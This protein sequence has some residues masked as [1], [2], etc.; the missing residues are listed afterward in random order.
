MVA[1]HFITFD[2]E[3]F[4]GENSGSI[5]DSLFTP[6]EIILNILESAKLKA[7][8]FIDVLHYYKIIS[9]KGKYPALE[10]EARAFKRQIE[11]MVKLGHDIQLH[12]HPHWLDALYNPKTNRWEFSYEHYRLHD[13]TSHSRDEYSMAKCFSLAKNILVDLVREL[14]STYDCTCFRAGGYCILPFKDLRTIFEEN[15]I[16]VDSSIL[17]KSKFAIGQGIEV[18]FVKTPQFTYWFFSDDPTISQREG[19]FLELP[20]AT[21][22][23][24]TFIQLLLKARR[25][26]TRRKQAWQK[27]SVG[28]AMSQIPATCGKGKLSNYYDKINKLYRFPSIEYLS[29]ELP[30]FDMVFLQNKY[31]FTCKDGDPIV[32][33]GHPKNSSI[34]SFDSLKIFLKKYVKKTLCCR[35]A[36]EYYK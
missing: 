34:G 2:Y 25:V 23:V 35:E 31:A 17:P 1:K 14:D 3:I 27:L 6:T 22:D 28:N 21:V 8:F 20:I 18:D 36:Y 33:V 24:G 15:G 7:T 5:L 32:F 9:F 10:V 30:I 4:F 13:L 29:C 19:K 12:I 26:L 16:L 11:Q